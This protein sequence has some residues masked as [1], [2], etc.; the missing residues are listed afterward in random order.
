MM[1]D[2]ETDAVWAGSSQDSLAVE[3]TGARVTESRGRRVSSL[4]DEVYYVLDTD[5]GNLGTAGK[6][7]IT[8]M[9]HQH[10]L[11]SYQLYKEKLAKIREKQAAMP[12]WEGVTP[13]P[14]RAA[15]HSPTPSVPTSVLTS[16]PTSVPSR[17]PTS[18]V[19]TNVPTVPSS[20]D[21]PRSSPQL[22]GSLP[23]LS[24]S[25]PRLNTIQLG[26][27]AILNPEN[28]IQQQRHKLPFIPGAFSPAWLGG[29]QEEG[30]ASSR[31]G[32]E[33]TQSNPHLHNNTHTQVRYLGTTKLK[34]NTF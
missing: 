28:Y 3:E 16:V 30:L 7:S 23:K 10:S 34:K 11:E 19:P 33:K 5:G 27:A 17:V 29:S 2:L 15:Q 12:G 22:G 4:G 20:A 32:V 21:R 18:S 31:L 1:T 8:N 14:G 9:K 25:P 6:L 26:L 24:A 13:P